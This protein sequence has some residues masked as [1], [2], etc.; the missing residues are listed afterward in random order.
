M[1]D[2]ISA[3]KDQLHKPVFDDK[4]GADQA[5]VSATF[6]PHLNSKRLTVVFPPWHFPEWLAKKVVSKIVKSGSNVLVYQ[7]NSGILD[8]DIITV[9]NSFE[10]IALAISE[11]VK[12]LRALH[13]LH[14][15]NLLGFSLGNVALAITT[16]KL[17]RFNHVTMIVPGSELAGPFWNNWRTRRLRNVIRSE[18]YKLEDIQKEWI[19]MAPATHANKFNGHPIHI[20]LAKKDKFIPYSYGKRLVDELSELN[21]KLTFTTRPFGHLLT[22]LSYE[23]LDKV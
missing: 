6:V 1:L 13:G 17:E 2:E 18:G 19:D 22:I 10:Y 16:E 23:Y 8:D 21:P 14:W 20:V 9:K 15:P 12:A 4:Y 5:I 7:F 11:D 3:I